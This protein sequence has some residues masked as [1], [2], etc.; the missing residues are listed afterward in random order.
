M[1]RRTFRPGNK[2]GPLG[3]TLAE[4]EL[5]NKNSTTIAQPTE[6]KT[7][8]TTEAT[9]EI[10]AQNQTAKFGLLGWG[11]VIFIA[12]TAFFYKNRKNFSSK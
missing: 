11:S 9:K 6:D 8:V 3:M 1:R 4:F 7:T 5:Q 10:Q 2:P 12:G